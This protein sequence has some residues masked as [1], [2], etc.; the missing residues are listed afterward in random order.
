MKRKLQFTLVLLNLSLFSAMVMAQNVEWVKQLGDG[1]GG[2]N[3][4]IKDMARDHVGNVFVVGTV[5]GT[6]D[7]DPGPGQNLYTNPAG[8]TTLFLA[9]YSAIGNLIWYNTI[10]STGDATSSNLAL[11]SSGN[12]YIT[13]RTIGPTDFNPDPN[14]AKWE[15]GAV[16]AKYLG[17]NGFFLWSIAMDSGFPPNHSN[18]QP[19]IQSI[20]VDNG[21][22]QLYIAGN[23]KAP[24]MDINQN[25]TTMYATGGKGFLIAF[26]LLGNLRWYRHLGLNATN[27]ININDM[28]T[29]EVNKKV[30][31]TGDFHGTQTYG[32]ATYNSVDGPALVLK[33]SA[34]GAIEDA[35]RIPNGAPSN[36]SDSGYGID[37]DNSGNVVIV[38]RINPGVPGGFITRKDPDFYHISYKGI[39]GFVPHDVATNNKSG[40]MVS[41]NIEG[42]TNPIQ[43]GTTSANR[44]YRAVSSSAWTHALLKYN[45]ANQYEFGQVAVHSGSPSSKARGIDYWAGSFVFAGEFGGIADFGPGV[46]LGTISAGG[47]DS[48]IAKIADTPIISGGDVCLGSQTFSVNFIPPGYSLNWSFN[49]S[50]AVTPNSGSNGSITVNSTGNYTGGMTVAATFVEYGNYY[51]GNFTIS[52]YAYVCGGGGGPGFEEDFGSSSNNLQNS[53]LNSPG[54]LQSIKLYDAVTGKLVYQGSH[55]SN[56]AFSTADLPV[57]AGH[58]FLHVTSEEGTTRKQIM[59]TPTGR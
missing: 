22:F 19:E 55:Q 24:F 41:G 45:S 32:V 8:S 47:T 15:N 36:L 43:P 4:Y 49:P 25:V 1:P 35:T 52:D 40:F 37:I 38:G 31:L 12:V 57:A 28:V 29:D 27:S 58:Y 18:F 14:F 33:W 30:Y 26:D 42:F 13:A 2:G 50:N 16:I 17:S 51:N 20:A 34:N 6:T 3:Q 39:S 48:F 46:G 59:I 9:K 44:L 7:F 54:I 53:G 23:F 5:N 56:K 21:S 11:D 10:P